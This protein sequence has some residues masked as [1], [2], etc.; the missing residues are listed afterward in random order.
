MFTSN[1]A[2]CRGGEATGSTNG[3][4]VALRCSISIQQM[5]HSMSKHIHF[6]HCRFVERVR[7]G[8]SCSESKW[9]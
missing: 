6:G 7:D 1:S 4:V 8:S 3:V 5:P 2:R 9:E